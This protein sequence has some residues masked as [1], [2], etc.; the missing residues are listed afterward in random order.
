MVHSDAIWNDVLEVGTA[1]KIMEPRSLSNAFWR[2]L[3][4]CF[5]FSILWLSNHLCPTPYIHIF[6]AF[7]AYKSDFFFGFPKVYSYE[8]ATVRA[9]I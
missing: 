1:E 9:W 7:F 2:Y 3:K 8:C 4:R 6:I 5:Y